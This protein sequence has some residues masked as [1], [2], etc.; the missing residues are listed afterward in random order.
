M[1]E[2]ARA[3]LQSVQNTRA[4][5]LQAEPTLRYAINLHCRLNGQAMHTHDTDCVLLCCCS[6]SATFTAKVLL[7]YRDLRESM[8]YTDA[9]Q[10]QQQQQPELTD[11]QQQQ[12]QQHMSQAMSHQSELPTI[13]L[14]ASPRSSMQLHAPMR[15][16]A[17][18]SNFSLPELPANKV[19]WMSHT[20]GRSVNSTQLLQSPILRAT[21]SQLPSPTGNA[22]STAVNFHHLSAAAS[23]SVMSSDAL[24]PQHGATS[25]LHNSDADH[26][27]H[28]APASMLAQHLPEAA[29]S[30]QQNLSNG[31][32]PATQAGDVAREAGW[33][34]ASD[35]GQCS[36]SGSTGQGMLTANAAVEVTWDSTTDSSQQHWSSN[37]GQAMLTAS[38]AAALRSSL[39]GGAAAP[40]DSMLTSAIFEDFTREV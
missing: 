5:Q 6:T 20:S 26:A 10:M 28:A 33:D 24:P 34:G 39:L 2:A 4:H 13:I 14:S 21:T 22:P 3:V 27:Q 9:Q 19:H 23:M 16:M 40:Q 7:C 15:A 32:G 36:L 8:K 30:S 11:H 1:Q 12:Q 29:S 25:A 31:K 38:V 18:G 35:S 37:K 17:A